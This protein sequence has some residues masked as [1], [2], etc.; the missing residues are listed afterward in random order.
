MQS[1]AA[2]AAVSSQTFSSLSGALCPH[3]GAPPIP[4][5]GP[6]RPSAACARLPSLRLRG[7]AVKAASE[8]D[9]G[10]RRAEPLRLARQA[11]PRVAARL[12]CPRSP[13]PGLWG[14]T[15]STSGASVLLWG[16]GWRWREAGG[17]CVGVRRAASRPW[18]LHAARGFTGVTHRQQRLLCLG[19]LGSQ[20]GASRAHQLPGN[21]VPPTTP[22]R[23]GAHSSKC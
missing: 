13:V 1:C 5:P 22:P 19:L 16:L 11:V 9:S 12:A 4:I 10:V 8:R 14:C 15:H 7:A 20:G 21:P 2:A 17:P 18:S 6:A 3:A 23:P